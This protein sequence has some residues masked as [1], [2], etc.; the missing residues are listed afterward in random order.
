[1]AGRKLL[2]LIDAGGESMHVLASRVR[3]LGYPVLRAKTTEEAK[4]LLCDPRYAVS[5]AVI[6]SDLPVVNLRAALAALRQVSAVEHLSFLVSG[7]R[8][9]PGRRRELQEAGAEFGLW[10]PVD[11]HTLRFQINRAMVGRIPRPS[12]R[13]SLRA[14]AS[15]PVDL[16]VG[17]R[18]KEGRVYSISANGAFLS[19]S[20]PALRKTVV[21]AK[22]ALPMAT[23]RVTGPVV[24]TNVPG[25]LQKRS[26]PV[27]MAVRFEGTPPETEALLQV[28]AEVRHCT[29]EV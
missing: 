8:P 12:R 23:V 15:W 28:Y 29:L 26:L 14:P 16:R 5:A 24:F 19:T 3:R 1:M 25:N 10:D 13:R 11:A 17:R 2:L 18:H 21:V 9:P 4:Q 6:P 20:T 22:M 27:G 7:G